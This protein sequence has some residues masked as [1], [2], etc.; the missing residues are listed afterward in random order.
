MAKIIAVE[1]CVL[2]GLVSDILFVTEARGL[3]SMV[4]H[5]LNTAG[6]LSQKISTDHTLSMKVKTLKIEPRNGKSFVVTC[7]FCGVIGYH[8]TSANLAEVC[9]CHTHETDTL[10]LESIS[11]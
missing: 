7:L 9:R 11:A 4:G 1:C 8:I 6:A 2:V 10:C 3:R 5:I